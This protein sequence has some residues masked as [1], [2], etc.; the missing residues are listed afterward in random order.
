MRE[1]AGHGFALAESGLGVVFGVTENFRHARFTFA[2]SAA[3]DAESI[4]RRAQED[5]DQK[6][7]DLK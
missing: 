4:S 5:Q 1:I 6:T 2:G 3:G 7:R